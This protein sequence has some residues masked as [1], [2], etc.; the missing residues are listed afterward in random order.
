V[1]AAAAGLECQCGQTD[2]VDPSTEEKVRVMHHCVTVNGVRMIEYSRWTSR[3]GNRICGIC[4][5]PAT[6]HHAVAQDKR[7]LP[8]WEGSESDIW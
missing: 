2:E 8:L 1:N 6:E 7:I 4:H 3:W 5:P